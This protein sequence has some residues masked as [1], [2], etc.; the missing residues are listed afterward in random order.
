MKISD[1]FESFDSPTNY[2]ITKNDRFETVYTFGNTTEYNVT[3]EATDDTMSI[4]EVSYG[5]KSGSHVINYAPTGT[6]NTKDTMVVL[7]T[8]IAIVKDFLRNHDLVV[9][10]NFEGNKGHGLAKMYDVMVRNLAT[11]LGFEY[12]VARDG[13]QHDYTLWV[14]QN[15]KLV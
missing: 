13:G 8:V 10:L 14:D 7:S 11:Q 1:I 4:F 12:E 5:I 2:H 15:T 3:F 9:Q 6:H